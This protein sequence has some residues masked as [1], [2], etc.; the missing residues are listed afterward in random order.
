M[1]HEVDQQGDGHQHVWRTIGCRDRQRQAN[2][3][4]IVPRRGI[5]QQRPQQER[6]GQLRQPVGPQTWLEMLQVLLAI[7]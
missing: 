3:E 4:S 2:P 5:A 7:P 6:K 1:A